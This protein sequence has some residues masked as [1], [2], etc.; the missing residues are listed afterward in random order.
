MIFKI[1]SNFTP[2]TVRITISKYHS[3]YLCQISLQIMLLPILIRIHKYTKIKGL[4]SG[5]ITS[6]PNSYKRDQLTCVI[7]VIAENKPHAGITRLVC[8]QQKPSRFISPVSTV[9][10]RNAWDHCRPIEEDRRKNKKRV[11]F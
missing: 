7:S 11:H 4:E 9:S 6:L 8:I 2:L 3:W 10:A 1:V 5:K